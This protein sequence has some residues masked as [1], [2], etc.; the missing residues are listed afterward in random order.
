MP[1]KRNL[2]LPSK[3]LSKLATSDIMKIYNLNNLHSSSKLSTVII[4]E[5]QRRTHTHAHRHAYT[6]NFH[7]FLR[8]MSLRLAGQA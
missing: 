1:L 5:S 3:S 6:T 7:E 4:K 8:I 2:K